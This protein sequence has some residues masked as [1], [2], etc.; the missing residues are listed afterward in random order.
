MYWLTQSS[1][2]VFVFFFKA[3]MV[4]TCRNNNKKNKTNIKNGYATLYLPSPITVYEKSS[5]CDQ[6]LWKSDFRNHGDEPACGLSTGSEGQIET[7][8]RWVGE[9]LTLNILCE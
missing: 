5:E 9:E 3:N 8:E 1:T 4:E 2:L 7:E 6:V